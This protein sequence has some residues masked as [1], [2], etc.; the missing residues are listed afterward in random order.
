M[1]YKRQNGFKGMRLLSREEPFAAVGVGAVADCLERDVDGVGIVVGGDG[2]AIMVWLF[3][4]RTVIVIVVT[5]SCL[6]KTA[7]ESIDI[8]H[9]TRENPY[10]SLNCKQARLKR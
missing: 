7:Y 5:Q 4:T 8:E 2:D 10:R 6:S 9:C 1:P 3:W